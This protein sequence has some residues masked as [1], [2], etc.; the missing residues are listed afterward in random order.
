MLVYGSWCTS[1]Q[2]LL[3]RRV[4]QAIGEDEI[5]AHWLRATVRLMVTTILKTPQLVLHELLLV[6]T[7]VTLLPQSSFLLIIELMKQRFL[8]W[9]GDLMGSQVWYLSQSLPT[10]VD[11]CSPSMFPNSHDLVFAYSSFNVIHSGTDPETGFEDF[12]RIPLG[13]IRLQRASIGQLEL[14]QDPP[15]GVVHPANKQAASIKETLKS[16]N[17]G[18]LVW[19]AIPESLNFFNSMD[20]QQVLMEI[21]LFFMRIWSQ[22]LLDCLNHLARRFSFFNVVY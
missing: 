7:L 9:A 14:R 21:H 4:L 6:S 8:S 17:C 22:Y 11:C 3:T 19:K 16:L 10:P 18:K 20:G 2:N 12:P 13:S 15:H 1:P 5:W